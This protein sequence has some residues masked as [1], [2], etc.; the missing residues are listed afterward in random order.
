MM[1][2]P[3]CKVT[4]RGSKR[5][6]V[7]LPR[8][9][10]SGYWWH[11]VKYYITI[12]KHK[13]ACTNTRLNAHPQVD[14]NN[15]RKPAT[16]RGRHNGYC[17]GFWQTKCRE[18]TIAWHG[19]GC[20]L[21]SVC[22]CVC[23]CVCA[24]V[25][26]KERERD[27]G[28]GCVSRHVTAAV[29]SNETPKKRHRQ[30]GCV[31][32]TTVQQSR[33]CEVK[34]ILKQ[35]WLAFP[36]PSLSRCLSLSFCQHALASPAGVWQLNISLGNEALFRNHYKTRKSCPTSLAK[37]H[38]KLCACVSVGVCVCVCR[39]VLVCVPYLHH[40]SFC[41]THPW[42][43]AS[44]ITLPFR[45]SP[46]VLWILPS[47]LSSLPGLLPS[48]R[49][50]MISSAWESNGPVGGHHGQI[51]IWCMRVLAWVCACYR[52]QKWM[53]WCGGLKSTQTGFHILL[54]NVLDWALGVFICGCVSMCVCVCVCAGVCVMICESGI[55]L[56]VH[57]SVHV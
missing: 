34:V 46:A 56:Y 49:L 26:E 35:V 20:V 37:T 18:N 21:V 53:P 24:C 45:Q 54:T 36:S 16:E 6:V 39:W 1:H 52:A 22:V 30:K 13:W 9:G 7:L 31:A 3:L 10:L 23:V 27:R 47:L 51:H 8:L 2:H 28:C 41:S 14:K 40:P 33:P 15:T 55:V 32:L 43:F 19:G 50:Q 11:P 57:V 29:S 17:E 48:C 12:H 5:T 25:C 44:K 42:L 38:G 4:V